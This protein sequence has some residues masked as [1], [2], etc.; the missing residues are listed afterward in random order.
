MRVIFPPMATEKVTLNKLN[1]IGLVHHWDK[2][3]RFV[4]SPAYFEKMTYRGRHVCVEELN[5]LF[6]RDLSLRLARV[7]QAT[8]C[9]E[10][11]KPIMQLLSKANDFCTKML[12]DNAFIDEAALASHITGFVSLNQRLQNIKKELQITETTVQQPIVP[13]DSG[14]QR[15]LDALFKLDSL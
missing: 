13:Q 12:G 4:L 15:L 11:A 14:R 9:L 8:R 3:D 2:K 5:P 7:S 10:V 6:A 1:L